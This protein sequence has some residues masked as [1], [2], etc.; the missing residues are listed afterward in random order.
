MKKTG[1]LALAALALICLAPAPSYAQDQ[2]PV[3]VVPHAR[4]AGL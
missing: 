2:S 4:P 1:L 3:E